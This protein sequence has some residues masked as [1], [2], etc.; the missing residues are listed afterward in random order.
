VTGGTVFVVDDDASVSR[1]VAKLV[2]MLGYE[3]RTFDSAESFLAAYDG[4]RGCL[5]VDVRMPGMSGLELL[6]ELASRHASLPAI[7]MSGHVDA[8]TMPRP[9]IPILGVLE[10]PFPVHALRQL[11]ARWQAEL[12]PTAD[13]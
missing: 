11:L 5:L 9:G 1:S 2:R 3:S 10:K 6:E 13:P 8:G 4:T 7:V 12:E